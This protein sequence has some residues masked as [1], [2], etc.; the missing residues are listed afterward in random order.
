MKRIVIT[1]AL[2]HIGSRLIRELPAMFPGA[3]IVMVDNLSTQRYCSLFNLPSQGRYRFLEAD[4]LEADLP[5]IFLGADVVI[6][7]AAI[8][9]AAGTVDIPER[10]EKVNLVGTERVA[11]ACIATA[12]PLVSVSTTS[13]YGVSSSVL[14]ESCS[15]EDLQPQSVYARFKLKAE[16]RL[17]ELGQAHNLDFVTCRFGTI[18]GVSPGMRFHTAVNKFVWQACLDVPLTVWRT[19]LNQQRPYLELGDAIGAL[20]FILRQRLF[21]RRVYNVVTANA[22]VGEIIE[23]IRPHVTRLQI[24]Y[25]DSPIMNQLSY[26]VSSDK[27]RSLGFEFTGSLPAEILATI[28]LL[29]PDHR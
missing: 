8:T 2:G 29:C 12:S 19:A 10:L 3:E 11:Q 27:F 18:F 14:D 24:D 23:Y 16:Q 7:L 26:A 4:V 1:G 28:R 9:D 13:V 6:H 5:G 17:A 21:D 20:L 25:V 22:T 15:V